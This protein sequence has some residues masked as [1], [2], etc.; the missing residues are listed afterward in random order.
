MLLRIFMHRTSCFTHLKR[1]LSVNPNY[2]NNVQ[3]FLAS[4]KKIIGN[5]H[6]TKLKKKIMIQIFV[7]VIP[8]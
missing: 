4:P 6:L 1:F 2:T 5:T 8:I 3:K 7:K